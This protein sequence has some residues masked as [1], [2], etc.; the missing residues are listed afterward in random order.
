VVQKTLV[1]KISGLGLLNKELSGDNR[2][3][4]SSSF[5]RVKSGKYTP[6]ERGTGCE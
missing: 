6:Q 1:K 2:L 4:G 5:K 3:Q